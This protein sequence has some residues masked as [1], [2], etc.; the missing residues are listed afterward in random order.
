MRGRRERDIENAPPAVII[1][2]GMGLVKRSS[3]FASGSS[4]PFVVEARG[5]EH[6]QDTKS[7]RTTAGVGSVRWICKVK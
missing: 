3:M 5:V 7:D 4:C 2:F 1:M 6:S